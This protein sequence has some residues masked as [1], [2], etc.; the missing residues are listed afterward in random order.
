MLLLR[1][2][3]NTNC[4][5]LTFGVFSLKSRKRALVGH[6]YCC[7]YSYLRFNCGLMCS[8][9]SL[10]HH[11]WQ[12]LGRYIIEERLCCKWN[13]SGELKNIARIPDAWST[14][15]TPS[16]MLLATLRRPAL[17]TEEGEPLSEN[18]CT[19]WKHC[20]YRLGRLVSACGG[21]PSID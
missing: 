5:H 13:C 19:Y 18:H 9:G 21:V 2:W 6:E 7:I 1:F 14:L 11:M 4:E 10:T 20:M 3:T 17:N 16:A 12:L 8:Y 15:L